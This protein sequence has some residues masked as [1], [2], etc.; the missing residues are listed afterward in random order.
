MIY[1][2]QCTRPDIYN[3]VRVLARHISAPRLVHVKG[4]CTVM[5]YVVATQN[6]G[7]VLSTN[8]VWNG[9]VDL[10][11]RSMTGHI[12]TMQLTQMAE[13]VSLMVWHF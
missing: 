3:T 4:I 1:M 8:T 10:S 13:G 6:G 7:L 9:Y 11:L 12:P 2:M 5:K